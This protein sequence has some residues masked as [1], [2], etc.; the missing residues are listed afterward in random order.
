MCNESLS[1]RSCLES[2]APD[3]SNYS[4]VLPRSGLFGCVQAVGRRLPP[5]ENRGSRMI[6]VRTGY[7]RKAQYPES[8]V[9]GR[10]FGDRKKEEG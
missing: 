1:V 8:M 7:C 6:A 2:L 4:N 9:Q 5:S 10:G 3:G